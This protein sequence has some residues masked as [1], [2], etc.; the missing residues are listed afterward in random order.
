MHVEAT[1]VA[2]L[3][4][5]VRLEQVHFETVAVVVDAVKCVDDGANDQQDGQHGESRQ[6]LSHRHIL[7][8]MLVDAEELEDEIGETSKVEDN[9]AERAGLVFVSNA[10]RSCQKDDNRQGHGSDCGVVF[11][12]AIA[13]DDDNELYSEPQEEEEVKLEQG[14][15]DLVGGNMSFDAKD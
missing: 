12:P 10:I 9:D 15:I 3:G 1:V 4:S 2:L 13:A 5:L 11:G 8:S 7:L 14:N 6:T